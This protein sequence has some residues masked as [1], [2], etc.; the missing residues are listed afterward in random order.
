MIP[1]CY[2]LYKSNIN[3]FVAENNYMNFSNYI[4]D[5]IKE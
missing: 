3:T 2:Y 4:G 1:E 5:L